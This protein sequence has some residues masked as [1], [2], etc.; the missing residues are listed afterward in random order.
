M[1]KFGGYFILA[2]AFI[3][4]L[5]VLRSA[6]AAQKEQQ[7]SGVPT[8][9]VDP[10]WPKMEGNWIF[11]SIAGITI[12]PTNDHVWVAQRPGTLDKD[13]NYAAQTPPRGECCVPAPP[14]MEFTPEGKLVQGW[15]GS[16]EGFDWPE[17][18]HGITI[19]YKGNVWIGGGGKNDNQILKFTKSGKLLLQ[20]GK[21]G[22][23]AGS[24]DTQNLNQPSSIFVY[25]KTNEAF[26]SDGYV[27]RRVIVFD[28]DSG[29]FKRMWG[30][31]GNKPDDTA[32]RIRRFPFD[33][34]QDNPAES[35]SHEPPPQQF[36]LVHTVLISNDDLVYVAD[37]S[38]NRI[39]VFKPDGT[40][41]KEAFVV[42]EMITPS[43]SVGSL[44]FSADKGQTFLYVTGGDDVLRILNR[45]T[46]QQVGRVGR[47]GH[48][49]GQFYHLHVM[50]V[51]SKGNIYTGENTGKRV[52][53]FL[54]K[55]LS[56]RPP[57]N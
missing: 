1:R 40:F 8:F 6:F 52:Q 20:I 46:L 38:S 13:E 18:E 50:A 21:S 7:A 2:I 34:P 29:A 16:G 41:I 48:Y 27:N 54:F 55:G 57:A 56:S 4:P 30:A 5:W 14:I 36:N 3:G 19:D 47:L 23:S 39:Q 24:N 31:Y 10:S 42:R 22:K 51:D 32:P 17:R 35:L 26:V 25:P 11:G 37:R 9:E 44:A 45:E 49:P 15:G 43:G 33:R 12:D 53:K 28:A